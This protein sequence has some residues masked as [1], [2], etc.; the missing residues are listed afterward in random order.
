MKVGIL[1]ECGRHGLEDVVCR[2]LCEL[3]RG[4]T[5]VDLEI[6]IVPMDNKQHLIQECGTATARLFDDGCDRVVI[7]WDERPAWPKKDDPLCWHN[8]RQDALTSLPQAQVDRR[9]VHLVCIER[10]FESWLLFD[11]RM[12]SRV[13]ST[14]AHPVR[15]PRQHNPDRMKNPKG[16]MTSLFRRH[17]GWQYVDIKYAAVFARSLQD[18]ARMRRCA[19]FR[20]F[21]ERVTG[22]EI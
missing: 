13:F 3:L 4:L 17:R 7:L 10:E 21:A 2:R 5:A 19:T 14:D 6:D 15:V 16:A 11:E 22:Q 12:L 20:R 8:D 18:L 1:V 9:S